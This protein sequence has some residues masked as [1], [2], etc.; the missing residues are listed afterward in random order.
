MTRITIGMLRKRAEHNEGCLTNLKEI[1]LHQQDIERLEVIGDSCRQLEI[2]YL[3]NNYIPRIEGLVHLK[4]LQ[5]LNL[6]VNNISVI[7]GLEGCEMLQKLDLTLNFIADVASV[8]SLRANINLEVLHLTGNSCTSVAGYRQ[9]VVDCLPQLKELDG[10]EVARSE[11]IIA[12]QDK[13]EIVA[14]VSAEA[15]AVRHKA[16]LLEEMRAKGIDPFPPKFNEQGER[17]YGHSAEERIQMLRETEEQEAAKRKPIPKEPGSIS[18]LYDELYNKKKEELTPEQ[19]I[20][21]HGRILQRNEGKLPYNVSEEPTQ[22]VVTVEPGK[23]ISTTL[24]D[25]RAETT[26]LRVTVKG[27]VLQ[28][29]LPT[30]VTPSKVTVQRATTSGQLRIVLPLAPHVLLEREERRNRLC[31]ITKAIPADDEPD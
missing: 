16:Q 24:I 22:I 1:A 4:H 7:E 27:K 10:N 21:K 20:E 9:F 30:E 23:F 8:A 17:V 5:Y 14:T 15:V 3:C 12:R 29:V 18:A 19:E 25:V 28:V 11:R 13:P 26:W 2:I 6:A 31:G